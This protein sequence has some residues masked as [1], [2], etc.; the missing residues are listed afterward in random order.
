[1]KGGGRTTVGER[2][3]SS[4][5]RLLKGQAIKTHTENIS[6]R[7]AQPPQTAKHIEGVIFLPQ[8][9]WKPTHSI[10]EPDSTIRPQ[11]P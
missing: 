8:G 5:G 2:K 1:M 11:P 3:Q 4:F 10:R 7:V 6:H 9:R